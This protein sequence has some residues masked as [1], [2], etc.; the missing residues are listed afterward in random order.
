MMGGGE[1]NLSLSRPNYRRAYVGY[2]SS[3]WPITASTPRVLA[4]FGTTM[5]HTLVPQHS[6]G[7]R[8]VYEY[9]AERW[10]R[11]KAHRVQGSW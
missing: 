1:N 10:R 2:S 3:V 4:I 5:P 9:T 6:M 7:S 8:P 11:R